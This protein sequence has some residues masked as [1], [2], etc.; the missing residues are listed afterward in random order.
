MSKLFKLKEWLTLDEAANHIS[1]VLG[2]PVTVADLYRLALD[3]HLKLS[4]DFVNGTYVRQGKWVR[5]DAIQFVRIEAGQFFEGVPHKAY[6]MPLNHEIWVSD[7]KWIALEDPVVSIDGIWDL[8][9]VGGE[10]LDIQYYYQQLTSGVEVTLE[11]LEGSFVQQGDV[12]CQLQE[13]FD[14]NEFQ[15]G[16]MAQ[17]KNI[18]SYFQQNKVGEDREKEIIAEY[19]ANR[20]S[21]LEKRKERPNECNYFPS[22]GLGP[23]NG[24]LVIRTNEITRFIQSLE[25]TP[26]P[27]K[28]LTSKERNSLLVLIGALCKQLDINPIT[29]GVASSLV[30]M[31]EIA[32]TPLTDDTI[33][34]ILHQI[35]EAVSLRSK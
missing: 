28:D 2:E 4:V 18:N 14:N 6:N 12:V 10:K 3:G 23:H 27:K 15:S 22:G 9:M 32:E 31:T 30:R 35:D 11:T 24:V 21:F 26:A 29:R 5:D 20:E 33:R 1:N 17:L 8:T 16:S 13:D 19:K 25:E 34:K 7:D